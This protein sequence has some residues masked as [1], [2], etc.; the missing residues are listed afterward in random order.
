MFIELVSS[1]F[2]LLNLGETSRNPASQLILAL[3]QSHESTELLDLMFTECN[4]NQACEYLK[5]NGLD[6]ICAGENCQ[7]CDK[8]NPREEKLSPLSSK[9]EYYHNV[10]F[11]QW[12]VWDRKAHNRKLGLRDTYCQGCHAALGKE[13]YLDIVPSKNST[14]ATLEQYIKADE[15]YRI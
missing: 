6:V 11:S 5:E 3:E 14:P 10:T 9:A 7:L 2:R 4:V 1:L 15:L 12:Y 13:T 8:K